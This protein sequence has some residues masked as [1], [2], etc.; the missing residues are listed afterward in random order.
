[1]LELYSQFYGISC[2]EYVTFPD[3][4]VQVL[5]V[6]VGGSFNTIRLAAER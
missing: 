4:C 2:S 5:Q 6:N 3:I 1:M